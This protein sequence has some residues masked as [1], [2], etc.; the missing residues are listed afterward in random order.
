MKELLLT[1]PGEYRKEGVVVFVFNTRGEVLV[2]QENGHNGDTG[3]SSGQR[4]VICETARDGE[5]WFATV[6]RGLA[7]ELGID[8]QQSRS[9]SLFLGQTA[10]LPH[11]LARVAAVVWTGEP[12]ALLRVRGDGEVVPLGWFSLETFYQ[13]ENLRPGVK[14]VLE[15]CR[16]KGTLEMF[17]EIAMAHHNGKT[18][19]D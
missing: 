1:E 12:D 10:F 5:D 11:V 16:Q 3:K 19:L 6:D 2:V 9:G 15:A 4:G 14:R 7:E 17:R 18:N 13:T 8:G